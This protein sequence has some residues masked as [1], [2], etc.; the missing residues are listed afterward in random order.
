MHE[1]RLLRQRLDDAKQPG[2]SNA[3]A[4]ARRSSG[5][6]CATVNRLLTCHFGL[7]A[8]LRLRV[9]VV[10]QA[11]AAILQAMAGDARVTV[12]LAHLLVLAGRAAAGSRQRA[13]AALHTGSAQKSKQHLGATLLRLR[14]F[15][16]QGGR[17]QARGRE[18]RQPCAWALRWTIS[19][20]NSVQPLSQ[21]HQRL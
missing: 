7:W 15:C 9:L 1:T 10:T 11:T 13:A 16:S 8:A 12:L 19:S 5:K 6:H 3:A 4:H 14:L 21:L 18:Q 17:Q 2:T 20:S